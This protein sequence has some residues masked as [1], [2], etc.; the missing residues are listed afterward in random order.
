M[1]DFLSRLV[2]RN[3]NIIGNVAP[4]PQF[5]FENGTDLESQ[6]SDISD[7]SDAVMQQQ[8]NTILHTLD[9]TPLQS[10]ARPAQQT[11]ITRQQKAHRHIKFTDITVLEP[12]S[13]PVTERLQTDRSLKNNELG[14]HETSN[15]N[16][17]QLKSATILN[18]EP[19]TPTHIQPQPQIVTQPEPRPIEPLSN[20]SVNEHNTSI[21]EAPIVRV[22]IGRVEIRAVQPKVPQQPRN[23][24]PRSRPGPK[25]SLDAY[26]Q[27][28][29]G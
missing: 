25:V 11:K 14:S 24:V 2:N 12:V 13:S 6:K 22:T 10:E 16:N 20:L 23:N 7:S 4:R 18:Q 3:H 29:K 26:L 9:Q 15:S 27:S 21:D 1:N 19:S 5:R 17:L 28:R 8:Q